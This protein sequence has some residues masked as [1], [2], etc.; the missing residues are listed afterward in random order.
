M[1]KICPETNEK[2][3]YAE[4][5]E[6]EE[7]GG[8]NLPGIKKE[9]FALLIVGSRSI[10][11][12]RLVRDKIDKLIAPIRDKYRFIVVSGGARGVDSLAKDYA[13][14]NGMEFHEMPADFD[15]YG[16]RAGYIRNEEMHRFISGYK[17][18]GCVAFWSGK[19][20]SKGTLHSIEL[21]SKYNNP[22]RFVVPA[23]AGEAGT[24]NRRPPET[25]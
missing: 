12:Y 18:R 9:F 1:A 7:R 2:V 20:E 19:P 15:R 5:L 17:H 4:C 11:D 25:G 6:C 24:K 13:R 3:L 8:C 16:K 21:A 22:I 10:T 23:K 14:E